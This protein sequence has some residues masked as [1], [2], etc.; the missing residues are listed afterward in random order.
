MRLQHGK[1]KNLEIAI[2]TI[3]GIVI[4]PGEVFSL[5]NLVGRPSQ[6]KGY[7]GGMLL[8]KG[9]V[10]EGLG[11]GL[12]QL[13]N[14]LHWMFLHVPF[15]IVER[16]HHSLDVFPDS[17]RT[18]PFGSGATILYNFID[19]KAKNTSSSPIQI[20]L[21]MTKEKLFGELRTTNA[22]LEGFRIQ[23]TDHCFVEWQK[24]WYRYNRLWR[25]SK[26]RN[27]QLKSD[28]VVTNLAPVLYK[29]DEQKMQDEG[30]ILVRM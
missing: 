28:L 29:I 18:V 6:R 4:Q 25:I 30:Y 7:V 1:I 26:L 15:E 3:D 14:L 16:Y 27:K 11:G 21:W 19:L 24:Q 2:A 20:H 5:W 23:E 22:S 13:A 12:C 9:E 17:G 8:S 10:I